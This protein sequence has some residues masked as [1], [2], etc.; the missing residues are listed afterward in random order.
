MRIRGWPA[1]MR[2]K[3]SSAKLKALVLS[4]SRQRRGRSVRAWQRVGS[5]FVRARLENLTRGLKL[6]R[7]GSR[8]PTQRVPQGGS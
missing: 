6:E 5:S 4:R 8:T 7:L 3:M 1:D 2:G